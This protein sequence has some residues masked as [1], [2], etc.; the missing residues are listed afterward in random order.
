MNTIILRYKF[1]SCRSIRIRM[2]R[3]SGPA[4]RPLL[5][6][7]LPQETDRRCDLTLLSGVTQ[8]RAGSV[9]GGEESTSRQ[10]TDGDFMC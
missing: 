6:G 8:V 10:E 1:P 2:I 7:G 4:S 5:V 9:G 3:I